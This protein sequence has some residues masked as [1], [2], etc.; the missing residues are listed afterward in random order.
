MCNNFEPVCRN[1][2]ESQ[3]QN[4][5]VVSVVLG[6]ELDGDGGVDFAHWNEVEEVLQLVGRLLRQQ[7][8][9]VVKFRIWKK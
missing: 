7:E 5:S 3:Q 6:R 2:F 4:E 1:H 9:D 8:G